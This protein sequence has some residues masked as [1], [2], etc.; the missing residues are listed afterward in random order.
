MTVRHRIQ[1]NKQTKKKERQLECCSVVKQDCCW[2]FK[3]LKHSENFE[4]CCFSITFNHSAEFCLIY[5]VIDFF[6]IPNMIRRLHV[7][8]SLLWSR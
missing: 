6:K 1:T 3:K 8:S 7:C 5:V 2:T 4:D